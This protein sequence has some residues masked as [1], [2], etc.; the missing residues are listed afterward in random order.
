MFGTSIQLQEYEAELERLKNSAS[1]EATRLFVCSA[2]I[3]FG[4]IPFSSINI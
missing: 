1:P 3:M 2:S 4:V